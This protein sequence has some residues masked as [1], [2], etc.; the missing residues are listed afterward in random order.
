MCGM[1]L[2]IIIYED[3]SCTNCIAT[4]FTKG[5]I[6]SYNIQ[7]LRRTFFKPRKYLILILSHGK[8]KLMKIGSFSENESSAHDTSTGQPPN[9]VMTWPPWLICNKCPF[10]KRELDDVTRILWCHVVCCPLIWSVLPL[11]GHTD[12]GERRNATSFQ[13]QR[14]TNVQSTKTEKHRL[15]GP[16]GCVNFF[17]EKI[18]YTVETEREASVA[19]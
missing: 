6:Q 19:I 18:T 7:G 16:A 17:L 9:I 8:R 12:R 5:G 14:V 4:L 1:S 15:N 13:V 3:T 10:F 2:C 11:C